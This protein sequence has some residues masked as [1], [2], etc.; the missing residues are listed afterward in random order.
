M[1]FLCDPRQR[2][3]YQQTIWEYVLKEFAKHKD[4]DFAY[5]TQRFYDNSTEGKLAK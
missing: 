2:R 5:P 4:I 3:G 1:R